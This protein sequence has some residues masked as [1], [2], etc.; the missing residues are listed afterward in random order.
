MQFI[1]TLHLFNVYIQNVIKHLEQ[2][3]DFMS[4]NYHIKELN[5]LHVQYAK[6]LLLKKELW[7]FIFNHILMLIILNVLCVILVVKLIL[8]WEN[9]ININIIKLSIIFFYFLNSY[10]KCN[11]CNSDFK[12]KSEYQFHLKITKTI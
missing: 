7:K 8:I 1:K 9:I 2:D 10:Y 12:L 3:I 4:M 6:N 5:L 11:L